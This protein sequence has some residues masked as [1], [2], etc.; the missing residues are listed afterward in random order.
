MLSAAVLAY[1]EVTNQRNK[2]TKYWVEKTPYNE[3][4]AKQIF[5]WWPQGKCIHII[6]DPRDNYASY[7][8]LHPDWTPE[9]FG[10]NWNRFAKIGLKNKEHF[11][12]ERYLLLRYEDLVSSP[13]ETIATITAFLAID[14]DEALITPTRAGR[15]W[16]GN[17]MF[18]DQF[19]G[20]SDKPVGRWREK[21]SPRE[22]ALI[23]WK[24]RSL[25]RSFSYQTYHLRDIIALIQTLSWPI[26]QQIKRQITKEQKRA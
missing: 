2:N 14:H 15:F 18:A 13:T 4:Y 11:G 12:E 19:Q 3:R 25:M 7:H 20:I 5:S 17:S 9:F 23:E 22:V 26:R 1:G 6:R 16:K 10:A 21:L 8:R 24:T